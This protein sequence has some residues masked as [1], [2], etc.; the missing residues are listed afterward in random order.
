MDISRPQKLFGVGPMGGGIS[1]VLLAIAV[2]VDR[3]LGHSAILANPAPMKVIGGGLAV[4]GL[5]LLFWSLWTLRNW[6]VKDE[7]CTMGPFKWF[8]HPMYAAWITFIVP[9]AALYLDSWILLFF[10]V[11][12][13]LIWHRLVTREEK[14]M[15]ETFQDEYRAYAART[16]RFFPRIWHR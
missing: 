5:G 6:W 3:L 1:L 2:W 14:M 15:L 11:L 7:L 12:I 13:H 9:A 16:G 4:I 8:R 10:V